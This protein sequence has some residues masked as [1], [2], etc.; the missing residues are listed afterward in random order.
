MY[1]HSFHG[2]PQELYNIVSL[3]KPGFFRQNFRQVAADFAPRFIRKRK[4]A[5]DCCE[6]L[7]ALI[8]VD[9]YVRREIA[10]LSHCRA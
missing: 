1:A 4:C 3:L 10:H 2:N 7:P 8:A 5:A 6:L 9:I